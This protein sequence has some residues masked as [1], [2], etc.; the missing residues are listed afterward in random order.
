MGMQKFLEGRVALIKHLIE[1]D[2]VVD[3]A[4]LVLII[5]AVLSACAAHRWPR[6]RRS[7]DK[8]RFIRLLIECSPPEFRT[9][10]V[11]VP[12]L[13]NDGLIAESDTPYGNPGHG[14][15]ICCD[16]E[17]DLSREDAIA[18]YPQVAVKTLKEYSY[19]SL[20]YRWL[21][22]PYSHE[23]RAHA[24]VTKVQASRKPAR[25]S[26]I[27]RISLTTPEIR[28]M[29]SFHLDYLIKLA[30]YHV[31]IL[32]AEQACLERTTMGPSSDVNVGGPPCADG[33]K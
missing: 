23:Y 12:A 26:Y 14:T 29:V 17:I 30:E 19:A 24:N 4:D 27:G 10:W 5:C 16:D 22:C 28:R 6:R 15:R 8:E 32:P 9:T 2:I 11:S 3:P 25:V 18:R 1:G 21:R 20:I 7:S 13:L 31:S 33:R